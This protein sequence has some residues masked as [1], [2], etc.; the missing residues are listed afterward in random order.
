MMPSGMEITAASA[1]WMSVPTIA[2]N[3]PPLISGEPH[4]SGSR[5]GPMPFCT[6]VMTSQNSGTSA[7]T[8]AATASPRTATSENR[9]RPAIG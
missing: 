6:R 5:M 1:V 2:L 3:A 7:M 8:R 4:Q 9:R